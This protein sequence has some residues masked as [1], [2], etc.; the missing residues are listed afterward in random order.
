MKKRIIAMVGLFV[1]VTLATYAQKTSMSA[2][3]GI[4]VSLIGIEQTVGD[5]TN[6][7]KYSQSN[8]NV[9]FGAFFDA[10]YVLLGVDFT[11]AGDRTRIAKYTYV[12]NSLSSV[13]GEANITINSLDMTV[14]LKYPFTVT[15]NIL[16]FPLAGV[17]YSLN[18]A[19]AEP[20]LTKD[21]LDDTTKSELNDLYLNF[22]LGG[23]IID[24]AS[25]WYLRYIFMAG[26]NLDSKFTIYKNI[27]ADY[28]GGTYSSSGMKFGAG[29][30][31]GYKF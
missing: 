30:F 25:N 17:T 15:N 12:D 11:I 22:G 16:L 27:A 14:Y 7:F 1:L 20:V 31:F 10:T 18:T 19:Y 6:G 3:M 8:E 2:G 23:D 29:A 13:N 24:A 26:Y 4:S 28:Y 5:T 21:D 9:S